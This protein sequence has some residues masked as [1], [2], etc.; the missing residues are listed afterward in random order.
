MKKITL[1]LAFYILDFLPTIVFAKMGSLFPEPEDEYRSGGSIDG[2][3]IIFWIV[4]LV[5]VFMSYSALFDGFKEWQLRRARGE[6]KSKMVWTK[7]IL[8]LILVVG[9]FLSFPFLV[10]IQKYGIEYNRLEDSIFVY[11]VSVF[12]LFFFRE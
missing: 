9:F 10:W 3:I 4:M 7:K 12:L 5:G 11:V 2:I 8:I 6:K 1:L